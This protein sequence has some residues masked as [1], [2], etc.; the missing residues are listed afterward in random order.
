MKK[1]IFLSI[2]LVLILAYTFITKDVSAP[3]L[4]EIEH[5]MYSNTSYEI[6]FTYP[7]SYFLEEQTVR[8]ENDPYVIS[9]TEDTEENR[10][11]REGRSPGREGPPAIT[12]SVFSAP[13]TTIEMWV[14]ENPL[15][16]FT[17][18]PDEP[19]YETRVDT[20]PALSYRWSGLYEG[21]SVVVKKNNKL[22]M[23]SVTYLTPGDEIRGLF[24]EIINTVTLE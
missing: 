3:A 13:T 17:L 18:P 5:I 16:N 1:I 6:S 20:I 11:M 2:L 12:L 7:R 15:S 24:N 21:E 9:L 23:F 14:K 22:Y 10:A 8:G 4:N 19:F